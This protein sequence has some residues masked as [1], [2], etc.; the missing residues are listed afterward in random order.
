MLQ[1]VSILGFMDGHKEN[2]FI[3]LDWRN[4]HYYAIIQAKSYVESGS[5]SEVIQV[6]RWG[7]AMSKHQTLSSSDHPSMS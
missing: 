5:Q 3:Y 1:H 6:L 4:E 2:R 7:R